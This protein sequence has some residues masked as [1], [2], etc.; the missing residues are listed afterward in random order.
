MWFSHGADRALGLS[1]GLKTPVRETDQF[2]SVLPQILRSGLGG[3]QVSKYSKVNQAPLAGR[4][5]CEVGKQVLA[6]CSQRS[7]L[8]VT[9][10]RRWLSC[11]LENSSSYL[12]VAL[13][14]QLDCLVSRTF[15]SLDCGL[16]GVSTKSFS[17]LV[18]SE[19]P[20]T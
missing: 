4:H 16:P 2:L 7:G 1:P 17:P 3:M 18:L 15:S 14:T 6:Q 8:T 20:G 10:G 19:V 13:I 12:G 11:M 5:S 9:S